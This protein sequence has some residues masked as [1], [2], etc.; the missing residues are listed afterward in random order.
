MNPLTKETESELI[1]ANGS[2]LQVATSARSGTKQWLHVSE[3]GKICA[4]YPLKADEVVTGS[5]PAVA[6]NGI[7]VIEST[8]EGRDGAFYSMATR[9]QELRD[10]GKPLSKKDYR[11]HFAS[12]WDADEYE[13][14]PAGWSSRPRTTPTSSASRRRSAAR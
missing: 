11:F 10:K 1:L 2:S 6:P 8:A 7:C 5:L 9:A 14:D 3:F 12:W 4:R 13:A